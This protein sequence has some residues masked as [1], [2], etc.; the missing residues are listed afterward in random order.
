MH[1]QT[2]MTGRPVD[3]DFRARP[4]MRTKHSASQGWGQAL[5]EW[6]KQV[7]FMGT[8][9]TGK[10]GVHTLRGSPSALSKMFPPMEEGFRGKTWILDIHS[11]DVA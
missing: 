2:R 7:P 5:N 9:R 10:I 6:W 3:R 8:R 1:P 4:I 11:P